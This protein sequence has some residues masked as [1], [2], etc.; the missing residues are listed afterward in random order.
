MTQQ[1]MRR[2]VAGLACTAALAAAP[3]TAALSSYEGFDGPGY[4]DGA[5]LNGLGGGSGWSGSW[6]A[7]NP[8][9]LVTAN[10]LSFGALATT[11][12]AATATAKPVPP[13]GGDI[14]FEQRQLGAAIGGD[15]TTVYLSLLLRPEPGFGFYGGLNLGGLFI[16]KSGPTDTYGLE[17]GSG[18][19]SS[20]TVA[21]VGETVL[22][23]LR[24]QFLAGND[25]FDLFV[26]PLPGAAEPSQ[27]DA[28]MSLFDLG[29]AGLVTINN[30]GAW[31]IDELRL[32]TSFADVTPAALLPAPTTLALLLAAGLGGLAGGRRRY[33]RACKEAISANSS[34]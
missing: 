3:A 16:G 22:L 12:G 21:Q 29:T 32:G 30:A 5:L 9:A 33:C 11:P 4:D 8:L 26:N 20:G 18:I 23:V 14:T 24:A 27:P 25:V 6:G 7:G 10:G 13:G 17:S 19:A 2:L 15:D 34:C 1:R 31:T 28:T